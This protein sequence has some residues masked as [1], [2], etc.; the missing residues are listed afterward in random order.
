MK[1]LIDAGADVNTRDVK[2]K[3][4]LYLAA[5]SCF[6]EGVRLLLRTGVDVDATDDFGNSALMACVGSIQDAPMETMIVNTSLFCSC[7]SL[8][9]VK[10]NPGTQMPVC[11]RLT[12]AGRSSCEPRERL[13]RERS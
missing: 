2:G 11:V 6:L 5:R 7:K 10:V 4:A 3:S 8:L 1:L 9:D 12:S 13:Q